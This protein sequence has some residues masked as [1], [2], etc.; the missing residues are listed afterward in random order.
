MVEPLH[1]QIL[2]TSTLFAY[3]V[4]MWSCITVK[5]IRSH[6]GGDR[7]YLTNIR[8]QCQIPIDRPKTDPWEFFLN[9]FIYSLCRWVIGTRS[10]K[11]FN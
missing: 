4:V 6:S 10:Q 8:Q 5:T 3:K 1:T 7:L 11:I 9:I 2:H